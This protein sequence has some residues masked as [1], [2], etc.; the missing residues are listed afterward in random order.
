MRTLF[1]SRIDLR[2]F[3]ARFS[4][5]AVCLAMFS[6]PAQSADYAGNLF[7][8]HLHYNI[9]A[10]NGQTGPHPP[11]DVLGRIQRRGVKA[12]VANSLPND[13][14]RSLAQAK[15]VAAAMQASRSAL[16][17]CIEELCRPFKAETMYDMVQELPQSALTA[18]IGEFHLYDS[19][20]TNGAVAKLMALA[21]EKQLT[22]LAHVD[23]AAIDL[24][25]ASTPSK[26]QKVRLIWVHTIGGVP[27]G[28]IDA[29]FT[30]Y[31]S[32]CDCSCGLTCASGKLW[33]N[34]RA[35]ILKIP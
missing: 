16:Y 14:T 17:P 7:D 3:S 22:V 10:W 31:P 2:E 21:E 25:M 26:G 11:T 12:I 28:R 1:S 15:T 9:E 13:G 18:G 27:L 5:V 29:R 6:V 4:V 24:L 8:A 35:L 20:N 23:D 34:W 19:A 30:L 33:S 32:M